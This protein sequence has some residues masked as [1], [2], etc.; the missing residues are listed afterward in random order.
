MQ[1]ARAHLND[2]FWLSAC[3]DFTDKSNLIPHQ[4]LGGDTPFERLHPE[5]R[6]R[7]QG[8]RKFGQTAYVHI[9]KLRRGVFPRGARNKMHP[10]AERGILLG[11]SHGG[12]AYSVFLPKLNKSV[13]SSA[14]T[15][16]E[17]PTEKNFMEDLYQGR[18]NPV[19]PVPPKGEGTNTEPENSSDTD[20]DIEEA[21]IRRG[22]CNRNEKGEPETNPRHES[23]TTEGEDP[24]A[25]QSR[26]GEFLDRWMERGHLKDKTEAHDF[27]RTWTDQ[28][29]D[30]STDEEIGTDNKIGEN[31]FA[32]CMMSASTV[33][34]KE[35]LESKDADSWKQT[36]QQ[37]DEG[38]I[39]K[40]VLI[41]ERNPPGTKPL[42][43][44]YVL[45]KKTAPDGQLIKFKARRVVQQ[46]LIHLAILLLH[47]LFVPKIFSSWNYA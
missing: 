25:Q 23:E 15:F 46:N 12:A 35:A 10:R 9:D 33:D 1:I 32:Y 17:I 39:R 47:S 27:I 11:S 24:A 13:I 7:Y 37:E 43:T 40:E 4:A 6:P 30:S 29:R 19:D 44:R 41:Q 20:T 16:D 22:T 28:D 36:I 14:V 31:N 26:M 5:R 21:D 8:I 3:K 2:K 38:L 34:L 18:D 42:R 45:T